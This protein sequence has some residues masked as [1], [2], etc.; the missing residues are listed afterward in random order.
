MCTIPIM[1]I[2]YQMSCE[3][4]LEQLV[5]DTISNLN[6]DVNRGHKL[7]YLIIM[8]FVKVFDN[9]PH[10]MLLCKVR[11]RARSGIDTIKHQI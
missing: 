8:D 9:V 6:G 11:K 4:R 3:T 1:K 2:G 10:R 5:H 7:T